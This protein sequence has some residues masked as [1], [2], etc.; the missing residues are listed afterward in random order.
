[1]KKL[2]AL[3]LAMVM[4]LSL[5]ACGA[6]EEAKPAETEAAAAAPAP[7]APAEEAPAAITSLKVYGI[8]KSESPYF[9]NEAAS[10]EKSLKA[11]GE[12]YGIDVT[13]TFLN[14]DGD[15][16]KY[17][18]QID[19]AIADNADAI[20]TCIPDQ[21]MSEAVVAKCEAAGVP[22]VACDDPLKDGN[23]NKLA[24]WFGID[25]YNIGYAAGEWVA[26]YATEN[27]L[28]EDETVGIL[29]MTMNTTSSCVPRTE[30]EKQAMAD[31]LPGAFEG[32]TYEV[33]YVTTMEDAYNGA[34]AMI[35]GH[36]EIKSWL[37]MVAS[38][39]GA[40]GVASAIENAG[41][42]ET[43]CVVT[44]GCDETTGHWEEGNYSVIRA[45]AYFSGKV[46]G[47]AA[48]EAVVEYLVNGTEM[49]KEY[50]TP[51]V[52]VDPTNYQDHVL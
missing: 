33:D 31:K 10:I 32:R 6:K 5:A 46:V 50:A 41:L 44:L 22:V 12:E 36:P 13:W 16:E 34:S 11:K 26:D 24:P 14:C 7:E 49:P 29:Y 15:A 43:S 23:N 28:V 48:I 40:L 4:V 21:T 18:T 17:M 2:I 51:A 1:M 9:V 35:A 37:V 47:K 27:N 30:G 52:M 45:A 20:V 19:T 39:Q 8:Y 42:A 25:A 3:L 38:E